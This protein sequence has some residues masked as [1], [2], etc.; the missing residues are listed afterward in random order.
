MYEF[1]QMIKASESAQIGGH[2]KRKLKTWDDLRRFVSPFGRASHQTRP[3]FGRKG[4]KTFGSP[5]GSNLQQKVS[6]SIYPISGLVYLTIC[7]F[8]I[9]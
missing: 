9:E 1:E 6:R 4:T 2:K 7:L 5:G 3:N 8:I